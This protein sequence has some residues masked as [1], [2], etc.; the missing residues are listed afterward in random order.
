MV[1]SKTRKGSKTQKSA[2]A[3][4]HPASGAA[5]EPQTTAAETQAAAGG[6]RAA[7]AESSPLNDDSSPAA[8]GTTLEKLLAEVAEWKDYARRAQAE[9]ENAKKRLATQQATALA[10]ASERVISALIPIMDDLE[11]GIAHAHD[12]DDE[13]ARGLEAIYTKL[14]AVFSAEGIEIL[15]PTGQ[16]FDHN[17][18]QAVSVS[19]DE[20][21]PDQTVLT[22]LQKGYVKGTRVIR[23]ATVVVSTR[24]QT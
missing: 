13:M 4:A 6:A 3:G 2:P 9:F 22:T 8:P 20:S 1:M 15:D 24:S 18:A 10:H 12:N 19:F 7:A 11:Y 16:A 5:S 21:Q 23:P 17:T 14:Q